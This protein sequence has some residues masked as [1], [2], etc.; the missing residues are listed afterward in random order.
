MKRLTLIRH[1]KSSWDDA[2]L[3]DFDR[4]L[5]ERGLRDAPKIGVH[6]AQ[7]SITLPDKII[8]SP[9]LRGISTACLIAKEIGYPE[10]TIELEPRLYEASLHQL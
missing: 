1:A 4:P 10:D 5:N 2:S 8:S 3:P 9:A 7:N 6:L